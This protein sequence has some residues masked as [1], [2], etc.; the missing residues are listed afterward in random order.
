[1]EIE[2]LIPNDGVV[3]NPEHKVVNITP[4]NKMISLGYSSITPWHSPREVPDEELAKRIDL[5]TPQITDMRYGI[6]NLH[7]PPADTLIDQAPKLDS[8]LKP[9]ISGGQV[10]MASAGSKSVRNSI[11]QHQPLIG[12]HGHIHESRGVAKIGRSL[13]LNPGSEYGEGVLRGVIFEIKNGAL[14]SHA[15]TSG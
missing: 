11:E 4:R 15:F 14:K 1:L 5:L 2:S 13:C 9:V 3:M 7:C 8:T 12:L 10:E 6:F